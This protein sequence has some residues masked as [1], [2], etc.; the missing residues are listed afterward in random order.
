MEFMSPIFHRCWPNIDPAPKP[1]S[2]LAS[3]ADSI[4]QPAPENISTPIVFVH[5]LF[6]SIENLGMITR[7]LK[8]DF[9]IYA[10]DL[11]NHGRSHHTSEISLQAMAAA[12]LKWL[13]SVGLD[14]VDLVGHSLGGKVCME[15]ALRHPDRVH[16]LVVADI[17][18]VAYPRR[19]DDIFAAFRAVDLNTIKSRADAD[20]LMRPYVTIASTRSFL[21]KNLEKSTDKAKDKGGSDNTW[22]WRLN[23]EA[24]ES[25]YHHIISANT[26]GFR[27]FN[28]PVLF[29]KGENSSYI[30][31]I[32]QESILSLFPSAGV[33]VINNTEHWLHAEKPEIFAGLVRRFLSPDRKG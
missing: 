11:P 21:L 13:D 8:D 22:R 18:P 10:I 30:M 12:M 14:C 19:H 7:L 27:P 20:A 28:K 17:A 4:S 1:E 16:R 32:H 25:G 2:G 15:L 31:P 6:G 24:L 3:V 5:G 26:S 33:K 29:I 9:L 23:I